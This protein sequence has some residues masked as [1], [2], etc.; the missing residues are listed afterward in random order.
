[1]RRPLRRLGLLLIGLFLIAALPLSAFAQEQG[2]EL[3]IVG[4]VPAKVIGKRDA[5]ALQYK[6]TRRPLFY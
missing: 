2:L 6:N 1:M 3:D 5:D 4:G